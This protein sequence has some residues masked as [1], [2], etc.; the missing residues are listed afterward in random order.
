MPPVPRAG[1]LISVI[2][3][4]MI[5]VITVAGV[6]VIGAML[7]PG[8]VLPSF[9]HDLDLF[10]TVDLSLILLMFM[11]QLVIMRH[12]PGI[13]SR[14]MAVNLLKIGLPT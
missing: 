3:L 4:A 10:P 11:S 6:L 2:V 14:W 1:R 5:A 7:L 8:F 12:F 9:F 13:M